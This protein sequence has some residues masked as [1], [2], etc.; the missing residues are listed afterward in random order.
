MKLL[1]IS[2]PILLLTPGCT[3]ASDTPKADTP[4]AEG[5]VSNVPAPQ[6]TQAAIN[7]DLVGR[8]ETERL[9]EVSENAFLRPGASLILSS[10]G[11]FSTSGVVT[12]SSMVLDPSTGTPQRMPITT[13]REESQGTWSADGPTLTF[14]YDGNGTVVQGIH[15][16]GVITLGTKAYRR[17]S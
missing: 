17:K 5:V 6:P 11:S 3:K 1:I 8:Y 10:D 12:V 13:S 14:T 15:R 7:P 4:K 2:L 9:I 16:G